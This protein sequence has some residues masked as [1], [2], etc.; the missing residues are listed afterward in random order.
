ME[1]QT[2]SNM[3]AHPICNR[4]SSA[5][6]ARTTE[7]ERWAGAMTSQLMPFSVLRPILKIMVQYTKNTKTQKHQNATAGL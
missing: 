3:R 2:S 7:K 1:M 5:G 6:R 4:E